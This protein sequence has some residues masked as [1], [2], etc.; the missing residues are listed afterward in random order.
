VGGG[1]SESEGCVEVGEGVFVA[2]IYL[3]R[4]LVVVRALITLDPSTSLRAG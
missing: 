1:G 2:T 3:L 4:L